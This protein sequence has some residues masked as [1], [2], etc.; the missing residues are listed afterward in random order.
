MLLTV[1]CLVVAHRD[2]QLGQSYGR[3]QKSILLTT[4]S[5]DA[6]SIKLFCFR[7]TCSLV[8]RS[9]LIVVAERF[10][11]NTNRKLVLRSWH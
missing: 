10:Y 3:C 9:A 11:L 4:S 5:S 2:C 8:I 7:P 6:V 1:I